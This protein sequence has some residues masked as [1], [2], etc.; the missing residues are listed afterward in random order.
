MFF[1]TGATRSSIQAAG[2]PGGGF[3]ASPKALVVEVMTKA[4]TR[5]RAASSS[6]VSVPRMLVSTKA[7]RAW[8]ATWGLC[9]VAACR[10]ASTPAMARAT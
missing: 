10:T 8:V 4:R 6:R 5:A 2:A 1:G 7:S 3:S 9:S